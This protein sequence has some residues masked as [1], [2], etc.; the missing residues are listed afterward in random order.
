MTRRR[1]KLCLAGFALL[2]VLGGAALLLYALHDA[3]SIG[4]HGFQC[5]EKGMTRAE[6]EAILGVPNPRPFNHFT[7]SGRVFVDLS[8]ASW[9]TCMPV[10][11]GTG[12]GISTLQTWPGSLYD[13]DTR[14][15][16]EGRLDGAV[17]LYHADATPGVWAR[18]CTWLND[19][20]GFRI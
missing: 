12:P 9:G 20:L 5:L 14:W 1:R 16:G 18:I 6:V 3:D 17:L 7:A 19:Y 11:M 8:V 2:F 13:I 10:P 15:D 4:P